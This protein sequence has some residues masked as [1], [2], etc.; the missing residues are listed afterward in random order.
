[1]RKLTGMRLIVLALAAGGSLSAPTHAQ[2]APNPPPA[3]PASPQTPQLSPVD[4]ASSRLQPTTEEPLSAAERAQP[5]AEPDSKGWLPPG[6][7]VQIRT[8]EQGIRY[9]SGGV[10]ESEREE[11]R[12]MSNE[13]SLRI[14]SAMQGGGEYLADAQVKILDSRGASMLSETSRG[15]FFLAQLPPG[16]YTVEVNVGDQMQKQSAQIGQ[17]Q[18]QLNFYWR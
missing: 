5:P 1:M 6:G 4:D 18:L 14:M 16:D 2:Q 9:A 12:A 10:G 3:Y 13:F 11:L 7:T 8:S 17:N 15:P